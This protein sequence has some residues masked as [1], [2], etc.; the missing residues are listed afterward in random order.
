[1]TFPVIDAHQHVWDPR[2]A[3]YAWL[4]NEAAELD[5]P[6]YF[7]EL[8]HELR[9]VGVDFTVQVQ[10]GDVPEDTALMIESA[11][12]HPEVAGIVGYAPVDR[13]DACASTIDQWRGNPLMVG[14]RTLI[15]NQPDPDWLLRPDVGE[16]LSLLA[17][18]GLTFDIVSVTPRHLEHV[19][20]LAARHPN[21]SFVIDH[22]SKPPVGLADREPW[23]TRIAAAADH[24]N[25]YGKVSGLYSATRT[26]GAWS[27][28]QIEPYFERALDLFGAERLMYGG[29]WPISIPEGGYTRV[30]GGLWPLF[31]Q[32]SELDREWIL[33]RTAATFYGLSHERLGLDS[34]AEA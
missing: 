9:N 24:T 7:D 18:A 33:G 10:S 22:L 8:R 27:T 30:W 32:L 28:A 26:P 13:P 16:G 3:H 21:L 11:E 20:I 17:Q 2:R 34:E 15:H 25:V 4:P 29:D 14:V 12:M 31:A 23:W 19:P 1:M 5:R 6:I